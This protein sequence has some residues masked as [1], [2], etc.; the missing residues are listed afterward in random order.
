MKNKLI[1]QTTIL[2]ATL[3]FPSIASAAVVVS[4]DFETAPLPSI[5][6]DVRLR[7]SHTGSDYLQFSGT[8]SLNAGEWEVSDGVLK[9]PG[10]TAGTASQSPI[11]KLLDVADAGLA[12]H[13]QL[14]ISFDYNVGVGSTLTFYTYGYFDGTLSSTNAQLHNTGTS[15]GS[16]QSQYDSSGDFTA[17]NLKNGSANPNGSVGTGTSIVGSGN[18]ELIVDLTAAGYE[19]IDHINDLQMMMM[20]FRGAVTDNTGAGA[21]TIDNFEFSTDVVAVPEPSSTA[22]LGL[23]GLALIL[24]RRK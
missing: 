5:A 10:T 15:N 7:V 13:T 22:L 18:F 14:T 2:A 20:G 11:F 6:T 4:D 23:G 12:D 21:I 8:A 9:N 17:I 19:E 24:R 1:I 16:I 3:A